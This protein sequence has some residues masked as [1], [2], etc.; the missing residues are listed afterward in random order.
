MP[1]QRTQISTLFAVSSDVPIVF[2]YFE[3]NN[4]PLF[5]ILNQIVFAIL[6]SYH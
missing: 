4:W 2:F 5:E 1:N 6:K 3:S